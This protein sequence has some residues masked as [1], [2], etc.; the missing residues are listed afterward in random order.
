VEQ[1]VTV[2]FRWSADDLY[3]GYCNH[4]RQDCRRVIRTL[5]SATIYAIAVLS[6]VGGIFAYRAGDSWGFCLI[7]SLFGLVWW[8]RSFW[9]RRLVR[10]QFARRPDKDIDI[11]WEIAPDNI[12]VRSPIGNSE[13][14]WKAF[15]KVVRTPSGIMFYPVNQIFHYLPRR[16]FTSDAEFEQ[17]AALAKS[18]VPTFRCVT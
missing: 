6:A 1:P 3:Q 10:W 17:V 12:L 2:R 13:L 7:L 15:A 14:S 11:E 4:R 8:S 9:H 18:K 16:G 5:M